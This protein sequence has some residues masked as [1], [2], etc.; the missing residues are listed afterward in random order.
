MKKKKQRTKF[1]KEQQCLNCNATLSGKFCSECGQKAFLNKE[2]FFHLAYEF[3]A[4]YFHFDG[5]FFSTIKNLLLK[6]GKLTHEYI[7]GKRKTYLN[8]IQMYLFVSAVFFLI[9]VKMTMSFDDFH[10]TNEENIRNYEQ[11]L[12]KR[13]SIRKATPY[14]YN[15][16]FDF[17]DMGYTIN[18][19]VFTL[20]E[21]DSIQQRLA[22]ENREKGFVR[23]VHRRA[24]K[25]NDSH[26][27]Y[28]EMLEV[29]LII[30]VLNTLPKVMFILLPVFASI[31]NLFYR[32]RHYFDHLIFSLHFHV[33]MFLIFFIFFTTT[34]F[35]PEDM[36]SLI[37]LVFCLFSLFLYLFL[38]LKTVYPSKLSHTILKY[39]GIL[40]TYITA[41]GIA[42][43]GALLF[44]LILAPT[45]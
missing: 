41:L 8:P 25:F 10:N 33:I 44:N 4:D 24:L 22:P 1:I 30:S 26:M 9:M 14:Q 20:K 36:I 27:N 39:L 17:T 37:V 5:K 42:L 3:T 18:G 7:E 23:Y 28:Q 45:H 13:D 43:V 15:V 11:V 29:N 21:Y 6:P 16:M 40:T 34:Y 19:N 12:V 32:R 38:A 2:S 35:I 31:I